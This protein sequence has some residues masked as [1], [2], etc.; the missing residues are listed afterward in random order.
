MFVV[1][2][3][4]YT[5]AKQTSATLWEWMKAS[6]LSTIE[7]VLYSIQR[8]RRNICNYVGRDTELATVGANIII[9]ARCACRV[10]FR[11]GSESL[12]SPIAGPLPP[13]SNTGG[14]EISCR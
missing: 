4:S 12:E 6:A 5:R 11:I 13:S 7:R 10:C 14:Y 3:R 2:Y 9:S 8:K 1:P